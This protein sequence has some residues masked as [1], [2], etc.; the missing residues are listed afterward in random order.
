M[1]AYK[2]FL[3]AAALLF[4]HAFPFASQGIGAQ[5]TINQTVSDQT[6]KTVQDVKT[7]RYKGAVFTSGWV[8][9][10]GWHDDGLRIIS[11]FPHYRDWAVRWMDGKDPVSKDFWALFTDFVYEAPD[12]MTLIYDVNLGWP[13]GSKGNKAKFSIDSTG[14]KAGIYRFIL[15]KRPVGVER[16]ELLVAGERAPGGISRFY[17][18]LEIKFEWLFDKLI[19]MEAYS[20]DM[21]WRLNRMIENLRE[22]AGVPESDTAIEQ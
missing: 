6:P 5:E 17:F 4:S 2:I 11:D 1:R 13:L 21:G 14:A 8:N 9:S 18:R 15:A 19:N 3:I 22:A 12:N 16:A 10:D 7:I 20:K